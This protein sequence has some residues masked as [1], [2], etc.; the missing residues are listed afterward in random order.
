MID[1][2][3]KH[4][5][6]ID[7][8]ID[9]CNY[10]EQQGYCNENY[11]IVSEGQ[12]YIAR[13]FL[14]TDIDRNFEYKVQQLAFE[15]NIT[16]E[17]LVFNKENGFMIFEFLEGVHKRQLNKDEL[18][19]L[20][21]ILQNL[22]NIQVNR[23]P[24]VLHIENKSDEVEKAFEHILNYPKEHTLCHN[25]LNPQN[26]FFGD[27]VKLIDWEYAGVN[28]RYF[29][30]ASVCIEFDLNQE[31]EEYFLRSYFL[32]KNEIKYKKLRAYK[33]IYKALCAQWFDRLITK[34]ND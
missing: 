25:D 16:A 20:A 30:L 32:I 1:L 12:K 22:H 26:I 3:K 2:L 28:D 9:S 19:R 33:V 21:Y 6:F 10:L 27:E 7:K 31:E 15:K 5:F 8:T 18:Q 14:R 24:I 17:P 13:K 11:V 23:A 34:K 29:D 4:D